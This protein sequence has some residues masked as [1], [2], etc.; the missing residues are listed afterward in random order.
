MALSCFCGALRTPYPDLIT[1]ACCWSLSVQAYVDLFHGFP[2]L[3]LRHAG[4]NHRYL[5]PFRCLRQ[6]APGN[7]FALLEVI[8]ASTH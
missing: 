2:H 6:R 1:E 8:L 7:L 3:S 4:L 5:T